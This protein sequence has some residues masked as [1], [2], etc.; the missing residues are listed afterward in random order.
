MTGATMSVK[1]FGSR[2]LAVCSGCDQRVGCALAVTKRRDESL[3]AFV[4]NKWMLW[5]KEGVNGVPGP[6]MRQEAMEDHEL[7]K[8]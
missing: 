2:V 4:A 1:A 3:L 5:R 6:V 8:E 7:R